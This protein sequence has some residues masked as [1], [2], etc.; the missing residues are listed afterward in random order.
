MLDLVAK[1]HYWRQA[2]ARIPRINV[3]K[4]FIWAKVWA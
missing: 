4:A 3:P 1:T 2:A